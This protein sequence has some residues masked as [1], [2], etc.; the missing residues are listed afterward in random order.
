M[1]CLQYVNMIRYSHRKIVVVLMHII[2]KLIFIEAAEKYPNHKVSIQSVYKILSTSI[3]NNPQEMR[4]VFSSLDNFKYRNKWWVIDIAGNHLRLI[5]YINFINQR[6][7]VKHIV[8]HKEYNQ[9]TKFY[10]ENS[11]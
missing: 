9:L 1:T 6:F 3:F 2:T 5:G 11:E 10:R 7:Y 4:A 8:T